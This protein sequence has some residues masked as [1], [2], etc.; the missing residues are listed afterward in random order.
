MKNLALIALLALTI[1]FVGCKKD[2]DEADADTES[3]SENAWADAVYDDVSS[4]SDEGYNGTL[5]SYKT[6]GNE[7]VLTTCASITFDTLTNPKSFTID[8]GS[9][10]CLCK[11][12][13]YRRGKIIV[14]YVGRYRDSLSSHSITF[15]NFYSNSNKIEG[16]K[17][18]VNNGRN[19]DGYLSYS[20]TVN[21]SII[22]DSQTYG[23][24]GTSTYN[25]S[26]TRV[27]TGG[28]ST[29]TWLDDVYLISGTSSGITR[30]GNAYSLVI[31]E[32]LKKEIGFRHFTDGTL[33][34]TPAGKL[35]RIIDF[36]YLNGARDNLARVT[37]NGV[38]FNIQLK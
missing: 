27:W 25:S 37:I 30:S 22:W 9:T 3:V 2:K 38:S 15:D 18:V 12:G 14:S 11:D 4:I 28:E 34:F 6:M 36:G 32:P 33:E 10:D 16:T 23:G 5:E 35:V 13:T 7:K 29:A 17:T 31:T 1:G 20:V 21:G 26:R 19:S 24:G 8:F